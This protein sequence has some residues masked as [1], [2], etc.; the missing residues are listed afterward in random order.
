M[1]YKEVI[2]L[3]KIDLEKLH[4]LVY[5]SNISDTDLARRTY[6]SREF[7]NKLRHHKIKFNQISLATAMKLSSAIQ[8]D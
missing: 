8:E 1:L 2:V 7:I 5:D 6:L 4:K 3:N